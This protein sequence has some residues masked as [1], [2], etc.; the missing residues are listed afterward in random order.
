MERVRSD[1]NHAA[2]E[3]LR[4]GHARTREK[5]RSAQWEMASR[6]FPR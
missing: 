1:G 2:G 6:Q 4:R 5:T 3:Y